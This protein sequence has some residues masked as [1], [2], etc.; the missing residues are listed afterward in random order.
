MA[1][2]I[3]RFYAEGDATRSV[4]LTIKTT[5]RDIREDDIITYELEGGSVVKW[6]VEDAEL[7]I[8]RRPFGDG[9]PPDG[10]VAAATFLYLWVAVS[11][12]L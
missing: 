5:G 8:V 9:V 7:Q 3:T 1:E 2:P 4:I 6:K 11:E 10:N 12:V